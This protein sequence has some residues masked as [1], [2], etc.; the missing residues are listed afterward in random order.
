MKR[1]IPLGAEADIGECAATPRCLV[2]GQEVTQ[3]NMLRFAL[4]PDAML[5]ADL[6]EKLPAPVFFLRG[7]KKYL[8]QAIEEDVFSKAAGRAVSVAPQFI[9]QLDALLSLR[10]LE[11]LGLARR[12]AALHAGFTKVEKA[13]R[14]GT[15]RL[16]IIAHDAAKDGRQKITALAAANGVPLLDEWPSDALSKALGRENTVHLAITEAGCAASI[17]RKAKRLTLYRYGA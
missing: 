6:A 7:E 12:Q 2:T 17:M 13:L 11:Q 4:A 1:I 3:D 5:V 10:A 9:E 16:V 8:H 15:A 14:N